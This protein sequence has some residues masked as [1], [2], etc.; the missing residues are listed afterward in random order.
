MRSSS[1]WLVL[2]LALLCSARTASASQDGIAARPPSVQDEAATRITLTPNA[3][4]ERTLAGGEQTLFGVAVDAGMF[5][6]A[7]ADQQGIDVVLTV[8]GPDGQPRARIDRPSD[9]HGPET[10]SW[11]ADQTGLYELQVASLETRAARGTV[12]VMLRAPRRPA[13]SDHLR[14][15][16]ETASAEGETQRATRSSQS[17][18]RAASAFERAAMLWQD[19]HDTY[20][21]GVAVYG[22]A[23]SL[24]ALCRYEESATKFAEA[25]RV[26]EQAGD[27]HG[28]AMSLTGEA[29]AYLYLG[30]YVAALERFERALVLRRALQ[31][32]RG[33]S[34]VLFGIGMVESELGRQDAALEHLFA[35][36]A[37]L[38]PAETNEQALRRVAIGRIYHR[39]GRNDD[40]WMYLSQALT[41]LRTSANRTALANALTNAGFVRLALRQDEE[42]QADFST[43]LPLARA[44]GDRAGEASALY[45]LARTE[46]RQG[47]LQAA[48]EHMNEALSLIESIRGAVSTEQLRMSYF[49][50]VQ[51]YYDFAVDVL[52]ELHAHTPAGDLAAAAFEVSERGRARSLLDL[53]Q[54]AK[55]DLRRVDPPFA[56]LD[57][58]HPP[59][60]AEI[61]QRLRGSHAL[62]LEYTLSTAHGYVWAVTDSSVE[63]YTLDADAATIKATARRLV[64]HL[65]EDGGSVQD[66][67]HTATELGRLLIPQRLAARLATAK[68]IIIVANDVLRSVPFGALSWARAGR[69]RPLIAAHEVINL[70]SA[71]TL[72]ALR[73]DSV[74]LSASS[75][76]AIF[77][78]A[79]FSRQDRRVGQPAAAAAPLVPAA[80]NMEMGLP[81]T[82]PRLPGTR[83]EAR[84][85]QRLTRHVT[86]L[87]GF[88]ANL[89]NATSSML[90]GHHIVHFATHGLVPEKHP[91]RSGVVLS[92]VD[93]AGASQDG[94]LSLPR[95]YG[96]RL[97]AQMVVLSACETGLGQEIAGEGLNGLVRGFM[98]AG[99][100]RIVA[101]LWRVRDAASAAMMR[102][103]YAG[104]FKQ[105]LRPSAALSAAAAA[106]WRDGTWAP[107]D[108][109]AF[110]FFGEWQ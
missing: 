94:Y 91:E 83:E 3:S 95:V 69:Y 44:V 99:S 92:L 21:F 8:R 40:A 85:I 17:L 67:E 42:A 53:L 26:M 45:G 46:A 31:E 57:A 72:T 12:R 74:G 101:T 77:A 68:T 47:Q 70:P 37:L 15:L 34:L 64:R 105:K 110:V 96:L 98:A 18:E 51:D 28:Q 80:E 7:V 62:L 60:L 97:P 4:I 100:P 38:R 93:A 11:M 19:M 9:A 30:D 49:A 1:W 13:P 71:A 90:A 79:V 66:F 23:W 24:R 65:T 52:M 10:I 48:R 14:I 88:D 106:M 36:L 76:I 82:L 61:Q 75:P 32:T 43:A 25:F 29:Y 35:S 59:R 33:E 27:G 63:G 73:R 56:T 87:Y 84:E 50:S 41:V 6:Q 5:V 39:L 104:I 22:L 20:E 2:G 86:P 54:A 108:W 78:D 109:S 89:R 16:A 102:R 55:V 103:F 107:A 58:P 81:R